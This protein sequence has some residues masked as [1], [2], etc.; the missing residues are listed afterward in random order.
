MKE[1]ECIVQFGASVF[2]STHEGGGDAF[3]LQYPFL[4]AILE[5][6]MAASRGRIV[7]VRR[8]PPSVCPLRPL[9]VLPRLV[10]RPRGHK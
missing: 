8:L 5:V 2:H 1:N 6:A 3:L 7:S 4:G 9:S 10:L